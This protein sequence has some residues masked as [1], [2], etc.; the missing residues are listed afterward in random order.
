MELIVANAD[1]INGTME[2]IKFELLISGEEEE[3]SEGMLGTE[4]F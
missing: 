2:R 4:E 1:I 3:E